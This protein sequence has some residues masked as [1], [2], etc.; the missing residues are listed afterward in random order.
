MN[1]ISGYVYRDTSKKTRVK[2]VVYKWTSTNH[3]NPEKVYAIVHEVGEPDMQSC[4]GIDPSLL[5]GP[6]RPATLKDLGRQD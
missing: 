1:L 6:L 4:Y 2:E 3:P 5:T